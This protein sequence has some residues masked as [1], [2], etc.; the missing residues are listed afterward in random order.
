MEKFIV[1][2]SGELFGKF[3]SVFILITFALVGYV[4]GV[5]FYKAI[6][7]VL[8]RLSGTNYK[9]ISRNFK[10]SLRFFTTVLLLNIGLAF[11]NFH[12][13][14]ERI[15][16]KILFI[17][18]VISLAYI[19]IRILQFI[20]DILY[21]KFD[22]N[23]TGNINERRARTQV[24]FLQKL[25]TAFV[26]FI[27]IAIVLMSFERVRELGTSLLAS[28]GIAGII[29]GFAAQKSLGNL[30]AGFQI[31]FTQPMRYDDVVIVQGQ[32]GRVEE[33]TLT[34]VVVKLWDERRL[35][36]PI[37]YFIDNAF[38]NW[39]R[40]S[41]E[42]LGAVV[43]YTDFAMPLEPMREE[44]KRLLDNEGKI[45]WNGKVAVVQLTDLNEQSM[46]VRILVSA[47]NSGLLFDLRCLI[48]EKMMQFII[49]NYPHCLPVRRILSD[50]ITNPS[51]GIVSVENQGV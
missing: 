12:D 25:G 1:Y 32:Y 45:L 31:A 41:S 51:S 17:L 35:I 24:D 33:I 26:I 47:F 7:Y 3:Q 13:K 16:G 21:L 36:L 43:L 19:L 42:M 37:S 2:W 44:L 29:I 20:K 18:I 9:A 10:F 27:S 39:T 34:Y 6:E 38:E 8:I 46:Q 11:T 23:I 50:P 22:V 28:A 14:T 15:V 30:L 48:R 49:Q 40:T 4:M 5:V